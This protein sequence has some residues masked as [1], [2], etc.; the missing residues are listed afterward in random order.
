MT[1]GM[2]RASQPWTGSLTGSRSFSA[3][4][5]KF[6]RRR[7]SSG[8]GHKSMSGK[9]SGDYYGSKSGA[10]FWNFIQ[11]GPLKIW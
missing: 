2:M 7:P 5:S 1:A 6:I 9:K 11:S 4:C 8:I 10:N 3:Y